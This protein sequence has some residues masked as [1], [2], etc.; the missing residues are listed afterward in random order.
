MILRE[1]REGCRWAYLL[2]YGYHILTKSQC[3]HAFTDEENLDGLRGEMRVVCNKFFSL[4]FR[5]QLCIENGHIPLG[6]FENWPTRE[7][8]GSQYNCNCTFLF[9]K[10]QGLRVEISTEG[11]VGMTNTD[12][13]G[14]Q[15]AEAAPAEK[16]S[17]I[18]WL[19]S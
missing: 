12:G 3:S 18:V 4:R 13:G 19:P 10:C 16:N 11:V 1:E 15:E 2:R 8:I 17:S 14:S 9:A 6:S 5:Q 7:W